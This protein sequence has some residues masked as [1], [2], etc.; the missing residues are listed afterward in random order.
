[1][2]DQVM[3][4]T[5]DNPYNPFTQW[6][7]W[8]A[9]DRGKGYYTCAYLARVVLSSDELSE[10]DQALATEQGIDEILDFNLTGKYIKVTEKDFESLIT[11]RLK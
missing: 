6:V 10:E 3:L 9:F 1:M 4:T 11:N 8:D 2:G 7:E 5:L